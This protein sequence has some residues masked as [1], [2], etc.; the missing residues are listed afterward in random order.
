[1]EM[2]IAGLG[3]VEAPM[4][5][6]AGLAL[7]LA[8]RLGRPIAK[9][10]IRGYLAARDGIDRLADSARAE[11]QGLYREAVAEYRSGTTPVGTGGEATSGALA[12]A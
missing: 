6:L 12:G 7:L 5:L 11:W 4:W 1:M 3:A 10:G 9:S 2:E 8:A